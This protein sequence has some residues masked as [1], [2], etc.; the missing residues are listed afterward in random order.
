MPQLIDSKPMYLS[1]RI[2]HLFHRLHQGILL[3]A[4]LIALLVCRSTFPGLD[5]LAHLRHMELVA[6]QA[7]GKSRSQV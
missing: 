3:I 6:R 7:T 2:A 4:Q 1:K 5:E